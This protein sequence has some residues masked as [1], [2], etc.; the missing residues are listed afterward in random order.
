M[1]SQ[2]QIRAGLNEAMASVRAYRGT[3]TYLAMVRL[4]DAIDDV[5]C[6]SLTVASAADVPKIQGAVSQARALRHALISE[7]LNASPV[8]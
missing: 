4:L 5:H 8:G 1:K 6:E 3:E 7:S 2:E